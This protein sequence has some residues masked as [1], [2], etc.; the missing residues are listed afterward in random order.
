MGR[1]T[2]EAFVTGE[3]GIRKFEFLVDTGSTYVGLPL[4]DIETLGLYKFPG[5][6]RRL[7]TGLG[8][9]ESD[10][11][12]ADVR[13]GEDR[14]PGYVVVAPVPLIGYE[15]LQNLRMRVNPV[16]QKLE[17]VPEDEEVF[18]PFIML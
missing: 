17:K 14:A 11:Y 16:T 5:G 4:E 3:N 10:T 7:M 9:L 15:L 2:V 1:T 8:L 18:P 6:T 12:A 13:I